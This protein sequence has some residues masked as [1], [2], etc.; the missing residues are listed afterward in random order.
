MKTY[1]RRTGAWTR[2]EVIASIVAYAEANG[3]TPASTD[4]NPS[5]CR[6]SAR[7]SAHRSMAWLERAEHWYAGHY[8]YPRTVA[9]LFG[10]WSAGVIA[11]GL[12]PYRV[13]FDID[14]VSVPASPQ[15]AAQDAWQAITQAKAPD[16]L[17]AS[18][19]ALATAALA[20]ADTLPDD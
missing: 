10:S 17:R 11:A 3:R 15:Q 13:P 7:I 5:D 12:Q 4:F 18:L 9:L 16:T 6:R 19:H 2:E 14:P 8:P 20:W 1:N